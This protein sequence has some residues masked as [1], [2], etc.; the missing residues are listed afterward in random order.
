MIAGESS[1]DFGDCNMRVS[2]EAMARHRE[3]IVAAASKMLRACGIDRMSVADL[4]Q[5]AG[6]T[7]G[8][9]YRHFDSKE[10]LVAEAT[11]ATFKDML[12]QLESRAAKNGAKTALAG[13]I[14]DYLSQRH[15]M[16]P[17]V[18]CPIAAY[19]T[20]VARED[21]SVLEAFAAGIDRQVMWIAEGLS[22]RSD[23][24][25]SRASELLSTLVG[26]MVTARATGDAKLAHE[27]LATA[28]TRAKKLIAEKG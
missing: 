9:F 3:E 27:I 7:H 25:R 11:A 17:E 19:G 12:K 18:G 10:A 26:A 21:V 20:E 1:P 14:D 6:L 2:R 4:M 13:Y 23:L 24:R 5:S 8:G 28:R 16:T 22:C 15:L